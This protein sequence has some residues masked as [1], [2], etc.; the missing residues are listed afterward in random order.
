MTIPGVDV[1]VVGGGPAGLSAAHALLIARPGLRVAVCE[2]AELR[3]RGAVVS[4]PPNGVRALEAISPELM[5][6]LR[7]HNN[8]HLSTRSFSPAGELVSSSEDGGLVTKIGVKGELLL[9]PWYALQAELAATLPDGVLHTGHKFLRYEEGADGVVAVFETPEG[10]HRL[11]ASLLIGCD[12]EQSAVREQLVGDGPPQFLG[13]AVW[14]AVRPRPAD[15]PVEKGF[16]GWG[17]LGQP[18]C[19]THTI[20][21][22]GG[23]LSWQA[24]APW[25]A[26]RLDEI[27]GGR[28]A[29]TADAAGAGQPGAREQQQAAALLGRQRLE[30]ALTAFEGYDPR[31]RDLIATT[32]P[33]I[34]IEHGQFCREPDQCQVYARGR[35]ALTGDAAHLGTPF[36]AQGCSQAIEDA[37]ELGRAVGA[38]GPTPEALAAYQ[39]VRLPLSGEVQE[40]SVQLFKELRSGTM[41]KHEIEVNTQR[42]FTSRTFAPL[43]ASPAPMAAA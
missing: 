38:H 16:V 15:W 42:G 17:G 3:P 8:V 43:V 14:R 19:L 13:R 4:I 23:M 5:P 36:L 34:V 35:V 32:D 7:R 28:R 20:G 24:F 9:L 26:D 12:G 41:T 22:D 21:E 30:R 10:T 25:P 31:L 40:A 37:L 39:E 29:Y 11:Q 2:R 18:S 27:G 6:A 33:A 1:C